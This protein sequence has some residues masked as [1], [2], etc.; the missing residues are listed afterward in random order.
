MSAATGPFCPP[1]TTVPCGWT[2]CH[3]CYPLP[4]TM[5]ELRADLGIGTGLIRPTRW[6]WCPADYGRPHSYVSP[7]ESFE[8]VH[9]P[10]RRVAWTVRRVR[11]T[12]GEW[13][14]VVRDP[15]G[16]AWA[17]SSGSKGGW[18]PEWDSHLWALDTAHRRARA[19][20]ATS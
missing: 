9:C 6:C 7:A 11:A 12:T 17:T 5:D 2:Y 14:W 1:G 10:P 16:V 20:F 4:Q 15:A 13:S 3:T 8:E 18:D 19:R